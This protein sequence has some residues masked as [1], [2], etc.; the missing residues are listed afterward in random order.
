M[1]FRERL[2]RELERELATFRD[3]NDPRRAEIE[4]L[5]RELR[6]GIVSPGLLDAV[7][8]LRGG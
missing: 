4:S 2:E 6:A 5:L 8:R 1:T 7:R 3:R